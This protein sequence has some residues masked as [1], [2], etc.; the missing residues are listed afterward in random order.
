MWVSVTDVRN[1]SGLTD[2][3]GSLQMKAELARHGSRQQPRSGDP[4]HGDRLHAARGVPCAA[5]TDTTVGSTCSVQ[6]T[7]NTVV[8]GMIPVSHQRMISGLG[9]IK[10]TDGGPDGNPDT[11]PS[12][13]TLFLD[14]GVFV[15]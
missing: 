1:K 11:N 13:N 5:T 6:T 7:A 12:E 2:Y 15:P 14:Q 9:Q 4:G 10:V 8:P 3:R